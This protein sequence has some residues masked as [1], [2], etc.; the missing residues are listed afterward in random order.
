MDEQTISTEIS[1]ITYDELEANMCIKKLCA[2]KMFATPLIWDHG[3]IIIPITL[4]Q[5]CS[6]LVTIC[7]VD[8]TLTQHWIMFIMLHLMAF[9]LCI[10]PRLNRWTGL[11]NCL[12]HLSS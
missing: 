9:P 6:M 10:Y 5:C 8:P 1:A 7:D 2:I 4:T 12:L 11:G 3:M